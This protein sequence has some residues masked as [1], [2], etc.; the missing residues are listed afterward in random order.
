[1]S[2]FDGNDGERLSNLILFKCPVTDKEMEEIAPFI[3]IILFILIV[4]FIAYVIY[5][6]FHNVSSKKYVKLK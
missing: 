6:Q 3:G 5:S 4:G 1:M 2:I